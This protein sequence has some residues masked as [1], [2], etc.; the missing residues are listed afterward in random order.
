MEAVGSSQGGSST[1]ADHSS[2]DSHG[3]V[4][5]LI[6]DN[7]EI[8][9]HSASSGNDAADSPTLSLPKATR[10]EVDRVLACK[11][12]AH[13]R[14][15]GINKNASANDC[16]QAY[17]RLIQ[18]VHPES[19]PPAIRATLP[20][21]TLD[22]FKQAAQVVIDA[23]HEFSSTASL[24]AGS[25]AAQGNG[26]PVPRVA[27]SAQNA[28]G[29]PQVLPSQCPLGRLDGSSSSPSSRKAG[30]PSSALDRSPR[31]ETCQQVS[32]GSAAIR[33]GTSEGCDGTI[34]LSQTAVA[35]QTDT[36][37]P[38]EDD[39]VPASK[40]GR[41][42]GIVLSQSL[43]ATIGAAQVSAG[44]QGLA[45]VDAVQADPVQ[46]DSPSQAIFTGVTRLKRDKD[47]H[48]QVYKI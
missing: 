16:R 4:K 11:P 34:P 17:L 2:L 22:K 31:S 35:L 33:E 15:L 10:S 9:E 40:K 26:L 42:A 47:K 6:D 18:I 44:A 30:K 36:M 1:E 37:P 38:F 28:K 45:V 3:N 12:G 23:Y 19:V 7:S 27:T 25:N 13:F 20:A 8:S 21:A 14:I 32:S 5:G 43:E 24:G 46:A 39:T 29:G 48:E 41:T